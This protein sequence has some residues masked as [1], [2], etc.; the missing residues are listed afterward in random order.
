MR[1]AFILF[2]FVVGCTYCGQMV[3]GIIYS[4]DENI[5]GNL[6]TGLYNKDC[7]FFNDYS[8]TCN[9]ERVSP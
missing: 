1:Y 5:E 9:Y 4:Y 2:L 7:V 8:Y 6:T 3:P